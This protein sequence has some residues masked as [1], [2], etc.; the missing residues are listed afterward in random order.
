MNK[1]LLLLIN[2]MSSVVTTRP[3]GAVTESDV[4]CPLSRLKEHASA[5]SPPML[6]QLNL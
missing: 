3:F 6:Q 4:R 2:D 5:S 1:F